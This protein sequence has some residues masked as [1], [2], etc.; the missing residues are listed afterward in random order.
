MGAK[1]LGNRNTAHIAKGT[2]PSYEKRVNALKVLIEKAKLHIQQ[3]RAEH[4]SGVDAKS[5]H[6]STT[7]Y[8]NDHV[9]AHDTGQETRQNSKP[10]QPS[11]R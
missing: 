9:P 7:D 5:N 2:L 10:S 4:N 11:R 8:R 3:E 6:A 1:Y